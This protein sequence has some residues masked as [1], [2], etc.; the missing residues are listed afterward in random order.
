MSLPRMYCIKYSAAC[1]H[2]DPKLLRV[3]TFNVSTVIQA[4]GLRRLILSRSLSTIDR[5][6]RTKTFA[7]SGPAHRRFEDK[8]HI[9]LACSAVSR[10][11]IYKFL[12][13][14]MLCTH[15]SGLAAPAN[16]IP[17]TFPTGSC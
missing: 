13:T 14:L 7:I 17:M 9:N 10:V 4:D 1:S 16:I 2:P 8:R 5:S 15:P 11:T 12:T 3:L 6:G